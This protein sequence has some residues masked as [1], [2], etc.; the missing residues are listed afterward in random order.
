MDKANIIFILT[1]Q[2]RWDSTGVHGNPLNLTPN[3]DYIAKKGTHFK[4][5]FTCQPLCG[6]ARSSLQTGLYP[7]NTG[8]WKNSLPLKMEAVTLAHLFNK[9]GYK[10]GYIGKK[11]FHSCSSFQFLNHIIKITLTHLLR[12]GDMLRDI[13]ENGFPQ[14]SNPLIALLTT[15]SA[16]TGELSRG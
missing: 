7:T 14:I 9:A 6:P 1:D 10:T 3:F 5:T 2:Q 8:V 15:S 4:N 12:R 16:V 11:I 13:M